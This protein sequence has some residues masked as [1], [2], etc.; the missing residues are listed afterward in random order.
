MADRK[1][2]I[3]CGRAIDAYARICPYCNWDQSE[4]VPAAAPVQ[5]S[6]V[7]PYT[8]PADHRVRNRVLTGVGGVVLVIAAFGIGS[9]VHGRNASPILAEREAAATAT[10]ATGRPSPRAN[11]TLVPVSDGMPDIEQPITSAPLANPAQGVPTEYQRTDATAVSSE[12]YAQMA[13]RAK[14]EKK[15]MD[16]LVDPRSI[17]TPVVPPDTTPPPQTSA[18]AASPQQPQPQP[19]GPESSRDPVNFPS[20]AARMVVT[21]RPVPTD[22]PLPDVRV[23]RP[24]TARLQLII[25]KDGHV[26]EVNVLQG[27][28]GETGKLIGTLQRRRFKPATENGVPVEAPF[29][30]DVSFS[31]HE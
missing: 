5:E 29:T 26:K 28:P 17:R 7:P 10:A 11:V 30:V 6:A 13:Q 24:M 31:P 15:K 27:I 4:P 2:C 3:K 12:E 19:N 20:P 9:L 8:P 18:S 22:Q 25:G 21:T 23:S 14:A 1:Q 16:V